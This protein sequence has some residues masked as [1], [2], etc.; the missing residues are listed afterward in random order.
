MRRILI[1]GLG[2]ATAAGVLS[3]CGDEDPTSVGGDIIEEGFLTFDVLLGASAFLVSDTT[4]DSIGAL[5]SAP[6]ALVAESFEGELFAHTLFRVNVPTRVT[7]ESE[8]TTITD[9]VFTI[10][11]GTV[12]VV[13]DTLGEE[14][15]PAGL[16]IVEVTE[17]WEAG[18][19]TWEQRYDTA[20]V[21]EAWTQPG[22]TPG[23][24]LGTSMWTGPDTVRIPLD[25]AAAAVL[26]DS[27]GAF[28]GALL[29]SNT[30]GT[31][32]RIQSL[33]FGFD[34][35]PASVDTI[36]PGGSVGT[37][38]VIATPAASP[39]DG[40]ELRVGGVPTWRSALEFRPLA[41]VE[42]PCSPGS[43]TCTIPLSEVNVNLATLLVQPVPVGSRRIE[44]PFRVEARA[45]LR[46][47][48]VPVSRSPLSSALG[49]MSES[50]VPDAFT[51]SP[52]DAGPAAVP[53]TG[54]VRRNVAPVDDEDPVLWIA[55]LAESER[56]APVFGYAAFGSVQSASPP[57]LRLVVTVPTGE[58]PQ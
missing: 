18:S 12:T 45:V 41:D 2:L 33:S 52:E 38:V 42:I 9:S 4:Y 32:L 48:G 37:D 28:H 20:G 22:G 24:T 57:M 39:A 56:S 21:S 10:V 16:E 11:G 36:V 30:A 3:A 31:R 49:R 54:Y 13:V 40:S 58:E 25:S 26:S 47:D 19:A 29:R 8:G 6:F 44:R 55:L 43:T 27:A 51:V 15:P 34:I 5:N 7:Y 46:A 23:E 35:R 14:T 53:I 50:L 17:S 1:L